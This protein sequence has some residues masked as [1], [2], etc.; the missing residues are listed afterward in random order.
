MSLLAIRSRALA[1]LGAALLT[2][3]CVVLAAPAT[4]RQGSAPAP[5]RFT[6]SASGDLLM[7][8]PLLD[9][10]LANG[11]GHEY[12]FAPFF[13]KVRPYVAG[14]D[15]GLC[16]VETPMGPG[17]PSTYPIFNTPTGLAR[18]IRQSGWDAC[19]TAS[20]HSLDQ[21]QAGIN[22]TAKALDKRGIAH[23][24]SFRSRRARRQPTLIPV[25]GLKIGFVAYTDATN[26]L[27]SPH[28][29]SV[30]AYRAS[31]PQAGAKK[32]LR[33]VKRADR[34]GADA[35]IVQLHWGDEFDRS[36]NSS[37]VKVAQRLTKSRRVTAVVGQGPHVVQPIKRLHHKFVVFSEGNLVSNQRAATGLPAATQDGLIAML[38]MRARDGR[39]TVR[40]VRYAPTWVRPGDFTVL[41]AKPRGGRNALRRSY[42]R[43]VS[44]A[45][46]SKRVKPALHGR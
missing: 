31:D 38:D 24:G 5:I 29:W 7:H 35:I 13:R 15:L 43:T 40:R 45:G 17:K 26:G 46:R 2:A 39:V 11:G 20:N 14:V 18:S 12:D 23:T 8:K 34:A 1:V 6:V 21:G 33:D 25:R 28:P 22:G 19:S 37:Q 27:S 4:G 41:P 36:P 32:I 30:N 3:V 42:R 9:R 44:V 10:A 16:H